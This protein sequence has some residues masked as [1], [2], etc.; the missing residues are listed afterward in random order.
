VLHINSATPTALLCLLLAAIT[1]AGE[2][3]EFIPIGGDENFHS[4]L[5]PSG[6]STVVVKPFRLQQHPVTNADYLQFVIAQP[7]WQRTHVTSLFV[8]HEYLTRWQSSVAL[9]DQVSPLQP[10]T[11]IS[12]FAAQ[13]YCES[14]NSR[15]PTWYEWELAAAASETVKNARADEQWRQHIL[16]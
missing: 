4:V 1:A 15:L 7:Q 8:N 6:A 9:G 14:M 11:Q 16:D 13:A 2:S 10:V 3:N 12:W 5:E